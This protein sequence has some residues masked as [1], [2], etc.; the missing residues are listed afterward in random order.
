MRNVDISPYTP[1]EAAP[2][3]R[4]TTYDVIQLCRSGQLEAT[5]PA[6]AGPWLISPD[7]LTAFLARGANHRPIPGNPFGGGAA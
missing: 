7:A 6:T 3:L 2:L 4:L 5:R 1:E